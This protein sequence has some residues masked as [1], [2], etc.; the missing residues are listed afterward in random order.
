MQ[1]VYADKAKP[2]GLLPH[3]GRTATTSVK[4]TA[5]LFSFITFI[6]YSSCLLTVSLYGQLDKFL[7][8]EVR[9]ERR[10]GWGGRWWYCI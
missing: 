3:L 10:G 8:C 9:E 7:L 6:E 4:T 2:H 5:I 1:M